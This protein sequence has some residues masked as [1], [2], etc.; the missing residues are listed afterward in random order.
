MNVTI[1]QGKV[2]RLPVVLFGSNSSL[3]VDVEE[4]CARLGMPIAAIVKNQDGDDH[5]LQRGLLVW[6][7]DLPHGLTAHPY[8]VPIFTPGHRLAASRDAASHGFTTMATLTD[9]TSVVPPSCTIG[10]GSYVNAGAIFGGAVTIG[11]SVFINRGAT[12][13]HHVEIADL[14]SIGP[15]A[16]V[17]GQARIGRGVVVGAGAVILPA[18]AIGN[19]SVVAAGTVVR[20]PVADHCLV[21]GNPARIVTNDYP[22]YRG[23]SV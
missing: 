1:L 11:T 7:S 20:E 16:T 2:A 23:L 14:V 12:I 13:G 18:I 6:A 9:P 17:A 4:T 5:A 8:L 15:G 21:A 3:I 19:N 22:G 10:A